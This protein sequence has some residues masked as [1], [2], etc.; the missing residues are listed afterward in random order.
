VK[1]ED[2]Y[3]AFRIDRQQ[4]SEHGYWFFWKTGQKWNKNRTI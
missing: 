1:S 4:L 3:S 2:G